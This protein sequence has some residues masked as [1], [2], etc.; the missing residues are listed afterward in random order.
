MLSTHGRGVKSLVVSLDK[1]GGSSIHW[2]VVPSIDNAP[3][4]DSNYKSRMVDQI[5]NILSI[6]PHLSL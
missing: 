1:M 2:D 4:A 3:Q 6:R 5:I